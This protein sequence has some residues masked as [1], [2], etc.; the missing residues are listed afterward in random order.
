MLGPRAFWI[1]EGFA[2]LIGQ[3]DFD[4]VNRRATLG[5]GDLEDADLVASA[6]PRQLIA[7]ERLC[8][9][10]RLEF[11]RM[12]QAT[13]ES[14]IASTMH[15]GA[16][17]RARRLSLFYAQSAMLARYLYETENGRYRRALLDYVVAFYTGAIDK[18]DFKTAFGLDPKEIGPKV[19]EFSK[20]LTQ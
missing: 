2:S 15:L 8:K 3:F 10:S 11:G 18:L 12:T 20:Q 9:M 19:V 17:Y 5:K 7:W 6:A 13:T 1:V 16:G 4:L 14:T